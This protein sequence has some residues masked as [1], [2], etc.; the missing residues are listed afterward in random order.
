MANHPNR[1]N[2]GA[3]YRPTPAEW[4]ALRQAAGLTQTQ[5]GD[6]VCSPL[7][8]VQHWEGGTRAIPPMAWKLLMIEIARMTGS[9]VSANPGQN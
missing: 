1:S 8:T 7:R 4:I 5:A 6:L 9:L 2:L 3:W